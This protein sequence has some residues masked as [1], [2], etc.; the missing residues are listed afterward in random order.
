MHSLNS[1][2]GIRKYR[3]QDDAPVRIDS[4]RSEIELSEISQLATDSK[5]QPERTAMLRRFM[6][7]IYTSAVDLKTRILG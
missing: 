3:I 2:A 6:S 5:A 7:K 1:I 4:E